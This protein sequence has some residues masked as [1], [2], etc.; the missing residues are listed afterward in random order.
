MIA[1][2]KSGERGRANHGWLDSRHTFS[3]ADYYDPRHMGFRAL[4]VINQDRVAAGRGF[5]MHPH[6]NMEIISYVLDGAIEHKDTMGST[7]ML[8]PGEV[9]LLSAGTGMAHSERNPS[10]TDELHFLQV[11]IVP[12]ERSM[13]L[14]PSYEQR[15]FPLEE[16]RNRLRVVSSPDGRDGST[17]LRQ[18]ALIYATVLDP[19]HEVVHQFGRDR[20]G[21]VH[22][23]RGAIELN[24]HSLE[25]GDGAAI[26]DEPTVALRGV[27]EAELLL[28]DLP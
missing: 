25:D 5:G 24:G 27:R 15:A 14:P 3:F 9:Q 21:W 26:S 7:S 12:D 23:T 18:D 6:E 10:P 13:N 16:R 28:F 22:V 2:R 20:F 11:W 8:R 19:G 1:L 17:K 4:R